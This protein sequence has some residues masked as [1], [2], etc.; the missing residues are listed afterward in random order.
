MFY[1]NAYIKIMFY[2]KMYNFAIVST[3]INKSI[4]N[5]L[6]YGFSLQNLLLSLFHETTSFLFPYISQ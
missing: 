5:L 6:L 2:D 4:Y 3:Y 1:N